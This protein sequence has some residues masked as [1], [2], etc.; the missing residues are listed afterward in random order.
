ME[1]VP[2]ELGRLGYSRSLLSRLRGTSWSA[3][4][5]FAHGDAPL[6]TELVRVGSA[7]PGRIGREE[8]ET[9]AVRRRIPI[10]VRDAQSRPRTHRELIML[11]DVRDYA[12]APIIAQGAVVGLL[13]VDRHSQLDLVDSFDR[14][15]LGVF[16]EGV[17]LAL[18]RARYRK[19]VAA[20]KTRFE[21]QA[22]EAEE[23]LYGG[24]EWEAEQAAAHEPVEAA[25][26]YLADGPL[27]ELTRRELE[28]LR[29]IA[30]GATNHDIASCLGVSTGTVKTHM[31]NIFRK[32]GAANRS[33]AAAKFHRLARRHPDL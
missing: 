23:L 10:L 14:D 24:V 22:E 16:A 19:R 12:A 7:M 26:A 27:A 32:L 30:G 21:R 1:Q 3:R 20:L 11:S 29:H 15:L 13:H 33:D 31:K 9:E 17:G 6:A 5:A 25:P 28:V 2:A 4:S 8:P 18:E